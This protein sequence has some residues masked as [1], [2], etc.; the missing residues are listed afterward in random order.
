MSILL[1][2]CRNDINNY[3]V[4]CKNKRLILDEIANK[5][6]KCGLKTLNVTT[7]G[8]EI[9]WI[10]DIFFTVDNKCFICN[11]TSNDTM[12]RDRRFEKN[13]L[14]ELLNKKFEMINIPKNIKFEG[15]DIIQSNNDIFIGI[16]NRTCS[17][18]IEFL[19]NQLPNKNII[20]I[21]HTSLHLDCVLSVLNHNKIIYHSDYIDELSINNYEILDIKEYVNP[22]NPIPCNLVIYNNN[23]ICS[24]LI[25]DEKLYDLLHILKYRVHTINIDNLWKEGGGIRCL[26]QWYTKLR[27]QYIY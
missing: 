15:G 16:G 8:D 17:E 9:I 21:T 4:S 23:I 10:R 26:T 19:R 24:D 3:N 5:L 6:K 25:K 12:Y 2:N 20:P 11:L 13:S 14:I 7:S 18:V 1:G 22:N 27:K